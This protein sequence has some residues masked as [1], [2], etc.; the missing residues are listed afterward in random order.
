MSEVGVLSKVLR[1]KEIKISSFDFKNRDKELHINVKPYKNGCLCPFCQRR[2]QI[3]RQGTEPRQWTDLTIF[4]MVTIFHYAPKEIQCPTH[5]RVQEQIPWAAAHARVTYRLEYRICGLC[6]IMTQKAAAAILAIA[7]STLS[8]IL[9]RIINR[10]RSE[11]KIRGLVTLGVDEI[12]YCKGHKYATIVYD[13]DRSCVVWV[14]KGKG[15]ETI[16]RFFREALSED[17]RKRVRWASCDMSKTYINA[18]KEHCPNATLVIDRFH[19]VKALNE[20]VDE[21]RKEEWRKLGADDRKAIKGLRW[22]LGMH[23][24]NRTKANTRVLN[25]LRNSNRRIHRAWVL[26]DEFDHFWNFSSPGKARKFLKRWMTAALKSR[27]PSLRDFVNT[28]KNHFDN[29]ITFITRPL[30]NAVAEGLNR[31]IK[32]VKNRASGFR[33]L[34]SFIDLIFLTVGDVDIPAQIPSDLRTL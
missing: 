11:H 23:A 6:Q 29:I 27:I 4:G 2:C 20:A 19:I 1:L 8:D 14:G 9:H 13:I 10:V 32:I 31:V 22:L 33:G 21:V 3:V 15:R 16:D 17:Q 12:S 25:E 30:T 7:T 18:I 24:R 34:E 28:L 5:G 26:K